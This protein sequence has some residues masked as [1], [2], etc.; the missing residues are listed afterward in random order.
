[1]SVRESIEEVEGDTE[2]MLIDDSVPEPVPKVE[3]TNPF[4][5]SAGPELGPVSQNGEV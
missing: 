3:E 4:R 1:L 2:D 5:K